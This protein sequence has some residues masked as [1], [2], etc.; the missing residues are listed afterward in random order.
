M[1]QNIQ[2]RVAEWES[3]KEETAPFGRFPKPVLTEEE[4][5]EPDVCSASAMDKILKFLE[6]LAQV[7]LLLSPA[8]ARCVACVY[9]CGVCRRS[10]VLSIDWIG[11]VQSPRNPFQDCTQKAIPLCKELLNVLEVNGLKAVDAQAAECINKTVTEPANKLL[12]SKFCGLFDC[13]KR[14]VSFCL[15][16][17]RMSSD[18]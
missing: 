8:S 1:V 14:D 17:L 18:V 11:R 6:P 3:G 13:T 9:R 4:R 7:P 12:E 15:F 16:C 2:M 10:F 5:S